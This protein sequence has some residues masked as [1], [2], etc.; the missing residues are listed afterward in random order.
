[1]TPKTPDVERGPVDAAGVMEWCV[2]LTDWQHPDVHESGGERTDG[3]WK[4]EGARR[5]KANSHGNVS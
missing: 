2:G 4:L 5:L 1:M 3:T